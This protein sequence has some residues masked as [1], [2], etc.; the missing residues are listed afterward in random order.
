MCQTVRTLPDRDVWRSAGAVAR[1][2][3]RTHRTP[4]RA[5]PIRARAGRPLGRLRPRTRG[6]MIERN[7][8]TDQWT[9]RDATTLGADLTRGMDLAGFS[10]E[11]SDGGIGKVDEATYD[12]SSSYIVVD[13]GPWIFGKKVMLPAGVIQRVDLARRPSSSSGRRMRSRTRRSSTRSTTGT[14]RTGRS[15]AATTAARRAAAARTSSRTAGRDEGTDGPGFRPGR[16]LYGR[17]RARTCDLLRVR[18]AL[19]QLS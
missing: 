10:V 2:R 19:S 4:H 16:R 1:L 5:Y 3:P 18:Q 12:T 11:A 15:S 9:Y 14:S 17:Y 6:A 7:T 13:T 8:T